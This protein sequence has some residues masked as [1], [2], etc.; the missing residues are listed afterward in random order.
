[1]TEDQLKS[2]MIKEREFLIKELSTVNKNR[3]WSKDN[4]YWADLLQN[5]DQ[6]DIDKVFCTAKGT[7]KSY[8]MTTLFAYRFLMFPIF[9]GVVVRAQGNQI[10]KSVMNHILERMKQLVRQ[11]SCLTTFVSKYRDLESAM[12]DLFEGTKAYIKH[13]EQMGQECIKFDDRVIHFTS[14]STANNVLG[15]ATLIPKGIFCNIWFEEILVQGEKYDENTVEIISRLKNDFFRGKKAPYFKQCSYHTLNPWNSVSQYY[16]VYVEE[17]IK[18]DSDWTNQENSDIVKQ[19]KLKLNDPNKGFILYRNEGM[20]VLCGSYHL[21]PDEQKDQTWQKEYN[22]TKLNN[23]RYFE[24]VYLGYA[25]VLDDSYLTFYKYMGNIKIWT[26]EQ[27]K[28]RLPF[29]HG[30]YIGIDRGMI[31]YSS[32]SINVLFRK[33]DENGKMSY[34]IVNLI[35]REYKEDSTGRVALDG[36]IGEL[37]NLLNNDIFKYYWTL[38]IMKENCG[39]VKIMVDNAAYDFMYRL[40][41]ESIKE[42]LNTTFTFVKCSTPKDTYSLND[43]QDYMKS[44]LSTGKL[45]FTKDSTI[46]LKRLKECK[47]KDGTFDRDESRHNKVDS[48]D[49]FDYSIC[50]DYKWIAKKVP[51]NPLKILKWN[52]VVK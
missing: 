42:R 52:I 6:K 13:T 17:F 23:I 32:I 33:Y 30:F 9:N 2:Y 8:G 45:S 40:R 3:P 50:F 12:D 31:D 1:M 44:Y 35:A 38:K 18:L 37:K 5:S 25:G 29:I 34:D 36:I 43:R 7:S 48:I 47:N 4:P 19:N 41:D 22:L 21:I 28:E 15:L 14:I 10:K 16:Q 46:L 39:P 49:A 26:M 24:T 27:L 11:G 20:M 51:Y